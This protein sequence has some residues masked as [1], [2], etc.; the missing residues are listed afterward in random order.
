MVGRTTRKWEQLGDLRVGPSSSTK[1]RAESRTISRQCRCPEAP[2]WDTPDLGAASS[3]ATHSDLLSMLPRRSPGGLPPSGTRAAQSVQPTEAGPPGPHF[4]AAR[5]VPETQG[6]RRGPYLVELAQK[7]ALVLAPAA[8]LHPLPGH[9]VQR[10]GH[11]LGSDPL[12]Q[13]EP[14]PGGDPCLW[15]VQSARTH[16]PPPPAHTSP[17]PSWQGTA[18]LCPGMRED[19]APHPPQ[20]ASLP[21]PRH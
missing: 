18:P 16:M 10:D 17:G 14:V 12:Q 4:L 15:S 6:T 13:T 21:G 19:K 3:H 1:P 5:Q 8:V 7:G 11:G 9:L 20:L 2:H